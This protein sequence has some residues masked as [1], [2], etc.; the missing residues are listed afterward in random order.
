MARVQPNALFE[1]QQLFRDGN[2]SRLMLL[3]DK[4]FPAGLSVSSQRAVSARR[5]AILLL[6]PLFFAAPS[7]V[8]AQ[9]EDAFR[10]GVNGGRRMS[11]RFLTTEGMRLFRNGKEYRAIGVNVPHLSQGYLGTWFHWKRIYGSREKMRQAIVAAV[12]D[13]ERSDAAFIRFF[14]SPGYP[15][16]AAELYLADPDEYWRL[17]D[18][19]FALC[20]RHNV[21]LVPSLGVVFKWSLDY[22]EFRTA[23]LDPD[24]KTYAA[25]YKY[26]REFV[27]R[28]KDDP[29]VLMWELE[30]EAFLGADVNMK[31]RPAKPRGV[32]PEGSAVFREKYTFEDSLRFEM[33][34]RFYKQM[35]A[36]IKGLDP[37]HLVTSGDSGPREESMCRRETF[38]HFQWRS[39]TIREHLSNLLASQPEPLDVFSVHMYGN[40]TTRRKVGSL[41]HLDFLRCRVRAIHASCS[42]VFVGELGQSDPH[43]QS[44]PEAKWTREAIDMLDKEGVA[45]IA[46]WVWR[47]PWQDQDYN[48]PHSAAQ[49]LLMKRISEFNEESH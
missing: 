35:T 21:G 15:K 23:V 31:D 20:R 12:I 2:G 42:P 14:A 3:F 6:C 32:Y 8:A 19:L 41:S 36:Y 16:G 25:T 1:Q 18:E 29:N 30:N 38:P 43:L 4:R 9:E 46:I 33:L 47:F 13:A 44:D 11:H 27:T 40:F 17:M 5:V 24:S 39:D 28:Y 49:P 48:I 7:P 22:G 45:L 10:A 34:V 26:V 37:N